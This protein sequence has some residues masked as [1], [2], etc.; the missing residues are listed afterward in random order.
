MTNI[1]EIVT[2]FFNNQEMQIENIHVI[3]R[4]EPNKHDTAI[5][6][7]HVKADQYDTYVEKASSA[8]EISI[9]FKDNKNEILN[10]Y[11]IIDRIEDTTEG[12]DANALFHIRVQASS[13]SKLL[14]IKKIKKSF[15][16][17]NQLVSDELEELLKE[18]DNIDFTNE[19]A[20][21]KIASKFR[22]IYRET[23][24]EYIIRRASQYNQPIICNSNSPQ[25]R[26]RFGINN[27][28]DKGELTR[29]SYSVLKDLER[30]REMQKN[31]YYENVQELD[32]IQF[33]IELRADEEPLEI[34]D[35]VTYKDIKFIIK[36]SI[37]E[38]R[39]HKLYCT[40]YLG[41]INSLKVKTVYNEQISGISIL[42]K[43]IAV[44]NNMIKL[45]LVIDETQDVNTAYWFDY[46][47]H[48]ATEFIMP[49]INDFV[50]LYFP[51]HNDDAPTGLNS[52][53][54]DPKKGYMRTDEPPNY[55]LG[56]GSPILDFVQEAHD[57]D[58]K[59]IVTKY[60]RTI[61]LKD[62][63]IYI[64]LDDDNYIKILEDEGITIYTNKH[65]NVQANKNITM[66]AKKDI[67]IE[68]EDSIIIN[69]GASKIEIK[70]EIIKIQSEQT[71]IN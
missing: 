54:Q 58:T 3:I 16:D 46:K 5:I 27:Y 14:D 18:F 6:T 28:P 8:T 34:S 56:A 32:F 19:A 10:F 15:Q 20:E 7:G 1:L 24:Y 13:F 30:F 68:A 37:T 31:N 69:S 44:E 42:G 40:Y 33:K 36:K 70:P 64:I 49:E 55:P 66:K 53:K 9:I 63:S 22:L 21:G 47:A 52:L 60:G 62:D 48:Y 11:G 43:V 50:N 51:T 59:M 67:K 4:K 25:L 38:I 2:I 39:D 57:P 35:S 26:F 23:A 29:Y 65:L 45:H 61:A 12:V 41:N 17:I 71:D